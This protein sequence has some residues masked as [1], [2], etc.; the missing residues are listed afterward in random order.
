MK[1]CRVDYFAPFQSMKKCFCLFSGHEKFFLAS[2][3]SMKNTFC[4]F[5]EHGKWQSNRHWTGWTCNCW[6]CCVCWT[7]R[8][9]SGSAKSLF[10]SI[11]KF[12]YFLISSTSTRLQDYILFVYKQ[13]TDKARKNSNIHSMFKS[14]NMMRMSTMKGKAAV[15]PNE[16]IILKLWSLGVMSY[17]SNA[18]YVSLLS[19]WFSP[20]NFVPFS[21]QKAE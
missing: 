13:S 2:F 18:W 20:S 10:G 3:L 5:S 17:S 19:K 1:D 4:L 15:I 21:W 8:W 9:I 14:R 16:Q 6:A 11:L 12:F 7:T